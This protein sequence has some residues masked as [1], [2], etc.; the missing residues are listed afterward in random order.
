[1]YETLQLTIAPDG[2]FGVPHGCFEYLLSNG[3]VIVARRGMFPSYARAK[4]EAL[5]VADTL[6]ESR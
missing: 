3:D 2:T 6:L 4:R 1:M 5:K